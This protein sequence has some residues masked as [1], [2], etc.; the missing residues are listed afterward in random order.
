M[1]PDPQ[2]QVE[3]S[4]KERGSILKITDRLSLGT[5]EEMPSR[6]QEVAS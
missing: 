6:F 2:R 3:G 5:T 4:F 1:W